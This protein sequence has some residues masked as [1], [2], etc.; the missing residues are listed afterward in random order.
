M[1]VR[2]YTLARKQTLFCEDVLS[3]SWKKP[4]ELGM[5]RKD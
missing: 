5:L 2:G 1:T 4:D 3:M